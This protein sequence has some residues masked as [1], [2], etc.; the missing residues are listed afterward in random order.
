MYRF[1]PRTRESVKFFKY[2]S[3]ASLRLVMISDV[4][5]KRK[6]KERRNDNF[7]KER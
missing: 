3:H 5:R 1:S 7:T 6:R 2:D 4:V